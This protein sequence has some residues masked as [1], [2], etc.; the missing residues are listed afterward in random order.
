MASKNV[1]CHSVL[2]CSFKMCPKEQNGNPTLDGEKINCKHL[3]LN[4]T[5]KSPECISHEPFLVF[6]IGLGTWLK[7][8]KSLQGGSLVERPIPANYW[9]QGSSQCY[10]LEGWGCLRVVVLRCNGIAHPHRNASSPI[11]KVGGTPWITR[12]LELPFPLRERAKSP[13]KRCQRRESLVMDAQS[14]GHKHIETAV[15]SS[16]QN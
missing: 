5:H 8:A 1:H 10:E 13:S 16:L 12:Q 9:I 11:S 2:Y 3:T 6:Q 4:I 14:V 7:N 15:L